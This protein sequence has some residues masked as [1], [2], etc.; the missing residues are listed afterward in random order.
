MEAASKYCP[1]LPLKNWLDSLMLVGWLSLY[2]YGLRARV[3]GIVDLLL[4]AWGEGAR[5]S[6]SLLRKRIYAIGNFVYERRMESVSF[7][8]EILAYFCD[9]GEER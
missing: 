4:L 8:K 2:L 6:S 1:R 5:D 9:D 7:K 3:C